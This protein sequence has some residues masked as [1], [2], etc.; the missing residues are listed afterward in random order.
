MV[1]TGGKIGASR[2][3]IESD[4]WDWPL[5]GLRHPPEGDTTGWYLWTGEL[6]QDQDFFLSWHVA[7]A[8]DRCPD[9]APLLELPPGSRFVYAPDYT[10]VWPDDSSLEL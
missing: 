4:A 10:D 6:Q 8:L 9:L 2:S 7:H 5:H 1:T 3:V